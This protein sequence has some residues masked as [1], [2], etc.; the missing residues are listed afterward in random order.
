M[1]KSPLGIMRDFDNCSITFDIMLKFDVLT[2]LSWLVS[3]NEDCRGLRSQ[4]Q[5]IEKV[6]PNIFFVTTRCVVRVCNVEN[7]MCCFK[8]SSWPSPA[9]DFQI[10]WGQT[11][12]RGI[13]CPPPFDMNTYDKSKW[14]W[15]KFPLPLF[16]PSGLSWQMK[17]RCS[18]WQINNSLLIFFTEF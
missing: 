2:L 15:V 3:A 9:E 12:V 4:E 14:D 5:E 17:E 16:V 8:V 1:E 11:Y 6:F 13:I 10:R 7:Q 18:G